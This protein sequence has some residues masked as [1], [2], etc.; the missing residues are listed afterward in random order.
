MRFGICDFDLLDLG[1]LV[2]VF[3]ESAIYFCRERMDR[4]G[5]ERRFDFPG[6]ASAGKDSAD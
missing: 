2:S 5:S 4:C 1:G 3:V 6:K